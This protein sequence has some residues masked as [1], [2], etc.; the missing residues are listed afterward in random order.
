MRKLKAQN[1]AVVCRDV[2]LTNEQDLTAGEIDTIFG[3]IKPESQPSINFAQF[4][5]GLRFCAMVKR[6]SLNDVVYAIVAV[7]GPVQPSLV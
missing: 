4:L 7:G 2:K 6:M 3:K 5:E 1:C